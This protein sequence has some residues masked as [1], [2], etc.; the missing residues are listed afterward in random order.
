MKIIS[1]KI[2]SWKYQCTITHIN[3]TISFVYIHCSP[4]ITWSIFYFCYLKCWKL[5]HWLL[6]QKVIKKIPSTKIMFIHGPLNWHEHKERYNIQSISHFHRTGKYQNR[7][8]H[9][10]NYQLMNTRRKQ[11]KITLLL[12]SFAYM[13]KMYGKHR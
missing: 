5:N 2:K 9:N 4:H 1:Y 11:A 6:H 7:V 10:I 8:I 12:T 3:T 13:S